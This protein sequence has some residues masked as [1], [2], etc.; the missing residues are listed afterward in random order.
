FLDI[1]SNFTQR[2]LR[3]RVIHL[4]RTA[5]AKLWWALG[6]LAKRPV[7]SRRKFG[8]IAHN[9]SLIETNS[10][11][12]L[13]N[14]AN[15]TVHHVARRHHVGSRCSVGDRSF[16]QELYGFVVENMEMIP[17]DA[18]NTTVAVA[19]VFAQAD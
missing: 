10:V 17:V 2:F 1:Q 13:A 14:S 8:R 9:P 11:E 12:C 6:S 5:I 3:V 19:H 4:V 16:N 15:A 18:R 7:K